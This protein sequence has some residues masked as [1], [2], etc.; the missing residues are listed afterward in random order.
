MKP[1]MQL[2]AT[3]CILNGQHAKVWMWHC[4][5]RTGTLG[6]SHDMDEAYALWQQCYR[7][8]HHTAQLWPPHV[9]WVAGGWPLHVRLAR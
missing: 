5:D 2:K 1:F 8:G 3:L 4:Y 9:E 7:I 6:V